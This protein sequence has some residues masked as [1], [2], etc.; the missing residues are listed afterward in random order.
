FL[1][2]FY[3]SLRDLYLPFCARDKLCPTEVPHG[4]TASSFGQVLSDFLLSLLTLNASMYESYFMFSPSARVA[5]PAYYG[6]C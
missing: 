6:F 4:F 5:T 1:Q 2:Q 3:N